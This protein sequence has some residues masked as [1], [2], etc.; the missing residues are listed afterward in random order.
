MAIFTY[1][2]VIFYIAFC[3]YEYILF[4]DVC[5]IRC[6][7]KKN[8]QIYVSTI[9]WTF[10]FGYIFP[11]FYIWNTNFGE[12]ATLS[13]TGFQIGDALIVVGLTVDM[14]TGKKDGFKNVKE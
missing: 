8:L 1:S 11:G 4:L 9:I 13:I 3:L 7:S 2:P 6:K 10:Y 12:Q 14:A 5:Y